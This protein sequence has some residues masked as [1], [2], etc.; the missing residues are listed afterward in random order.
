MCRK[1]AAMSAPWVKTGLSP[2]VGPFPGWVI[3]PLPFTLFNWAQWWGWAP[4]LL[5]LALAFWLKRKGR[6][7]TWMRRRLG[8]KWRGHR[9]EARS[10]GWRRMQTIDVPVWEFDM[11]AWRHSK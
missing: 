8:A 3:L 9:I 6:T 1:G 10:L 4:F 2:M 5:L 11:D 7:L